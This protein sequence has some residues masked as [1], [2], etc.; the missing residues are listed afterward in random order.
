MTEHDCD[1]HRDRETLSCWKLWSLAYRSHPIEDVHVAPYRSTGHSPKSGP[2]G[3]DST[4]LEAS[5]REAGLR[6]LPCAA[7]EFPAGSLKER[8]RQRSKLKGDEAL[9]AILQ[10][11]AG[12]TEAMLNSLPA[13]RLPP[14]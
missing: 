4:L 2:A 6:F 9:R 10:S 3:L 14:H 7:K 13:A 1:S 11:A 5:V 8:F 12:R